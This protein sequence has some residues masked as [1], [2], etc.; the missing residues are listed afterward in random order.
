MICNVKNT[1]FL[2][3]YKGAPETSE[4]SYG[5]YREEMFADQIHIYGTVDSVVLMVVVPGHNVSSKLSISDL[6]DQNQDNRGGREILMERGEGN[7][8]RLF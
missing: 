2:K 6:T 1:N 7:K 8:V 4:E 5:Q 3:P